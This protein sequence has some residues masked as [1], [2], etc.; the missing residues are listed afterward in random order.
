[1]KKSFIADYI[2]RMLPSIIMSQFVITICTT[3]D[4]ALTGQFLG[5]KAV[6]AEGMVTPS[7]MVVIAV[8]GVMSAGNAIICSNESGKGNVDEINRVF[9]TTFS[10][11]LSFSAFQLLIANFH[12]QVKQFSHSVILTAIRVP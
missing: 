4:A 6:A 2:N 5:A 9:S 11:S 8:A 12:I 7:V 1:M 3:V 10:V